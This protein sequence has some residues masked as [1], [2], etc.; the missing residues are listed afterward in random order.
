M[1]RLLLAP[2][3]HGKTQFVIE[4]IRAILASEPLSPIVVIMPNSIQA[5]GF[6]RRLCASGGALGVEVHTFHTLYAELLTRAGQPIPLLLDPVRIRLLRD[7][8]DKLC[9]RGEMTHYAALRNKP[10]FIA[11]LRNTIEELKRARITPE[12]FSASVKGLGARL[13]ESSTGGASDGNFTAALG[14]PTLDGLGGVGAGAHSPG[15]FVVVRRMPERAA[16][17]AA[18]LLTL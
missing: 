10:G 6:R 13:E 4:Q 8:V 18:L 16:L 7:I 11:L 12:D 3:G 17:L 14:V 1:T 5:A 2:A 15:E 9:E